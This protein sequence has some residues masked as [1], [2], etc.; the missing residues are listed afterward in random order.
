LAKLGNKPVASLTY[1]NSS[2]NSE[3]V[4][5]TKHLLLPS[6]PNYFHW[7]LFFNTVCWAAAR[8]EISQPDWSDQL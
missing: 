6:T 3:D 7:N 4:C 2:N 1:Q 5:E 8:G